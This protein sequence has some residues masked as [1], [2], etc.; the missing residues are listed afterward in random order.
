MEYSVFDLLKILI[1]KWYIIVA[2]VLVITLLAVLLSYHSYNNA[3]ATYN[4]AVSETVKYPTEIG[5]MTVTYHYDYEADDSVGAAFDA[6]KALHPEMELPTDEEKFTAALFEE[7]KLPIYSS[8]TS[9]MGAVIAVIQGEIDE[10]EWQEPPIVDK[11]GDIVP[12]EGTLI[13]SSHVSFAPLVGDTFQ[14]IIFDLDKDTANKLLEVCQEQFA[15]F[16]SDDLIAIELTQT[17]SEFERNPEQPTLNAALSETVMTKP[18]G[19]PG[20]IRTACIAAVLSFALACVCI[21]VVTFV[22][23]SKKVTRNKDED[24]QA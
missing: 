19:R 2:V 13:V 24:S 18:E 17:A 23:E 4:E 16:H 7:K 20:I 6:L 8:L 10:L 14:I 12:Y 9:N 11:N 22:L 3:L 21:L 15:E 1:R 5:K